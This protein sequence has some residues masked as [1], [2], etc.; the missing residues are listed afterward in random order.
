IFVQ[1]AAAQTARE[2]HTPQTERDR[3]TRYEVKRH[4][5][6]FDAEDIGSHE[7]TV[8][9][10]EAGT[11][12]AERIHDVRNFTLNVQPTADC[13]PPALEVLHPAAGD[14]LYNVFSAA[15]MPAPALPSASVTATAVSRPIS[16]I[17]EGVL[18]TVPF[19][20]LTV[21]ESATVL[22]AIP[23]RDEFYPRGFL[24]RE[25][26]LLEE[27]PGYLLTGE[28]GNAYLHLDAGNYLFAVTSGSDPEGEV[29]RCYEDA[30]Y[31]WEDILQVLTVST[32]EPVL[33]L[34]PSAETR[35]FPF[36]YRPLTVKASTP[37]GVA[38]IAL[39]AGDQQIF[40]STMDDVI[41][42][43]DPK[44]PSHLGFYKNVLF[45]HPAPAALDVTAIAAC[46]LSTTQNI[47]ISIQPDPP[48]TVGF[49]LLEEALE[50]RMGV[51][52]HLTAVVDD[53]GRNVAAL[54]A[55]LYAVGTAP[56]AA[57]LTP[58]NYRAGAAG[59][60]G[61][62]RFFE[63]IGNTEPLSIDN[64]SFQL[65]IKVRPPNVPLGDYE[66]RLLAFDDFDQAGLSAPLPIRILPPTLPPFLE[67]TLPDYRIPAGETIPVAIQLDHLGPL[68][69]VEIQ[70]VSA[71]AQPT[72][73]IIDL[74]GEAE[75]TATELIQI[76]ALASPGDTVDITV[77]AVDSA[78]LTS[79]FM[80]QVEVGVW[81]DP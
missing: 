44:R 22:F 59:E 42:T 55:V 30:C 51:Q 15:T 43:L 34:T 17:S 49:T 16:S 47:P 29:Y 32:D 79:T 65:P 78:G 58:D 57:T 40:L 45:A 64:F 2:T 38:G 46:G 37:T 52:T 54:H 39:Q 62:F 5:Y 10:R 25:E 3:N 60:L 80:D 6:T 31:D 75:F 53:P 41:Y 68:D 8:R 71:A 19:F 76:S 26:E 18:Y 28:D 67:V 1:S 12:G 73:R 4:Y 66:L 23:Y 63:N 21:T 74:E 69:H 70:A 7:L 72:V 56:D 81:G 77:T 36:D 61:T 27:I 14:T 50:L 20:N 24:Y 35:Q 48:P 33:Q 13:Q 11:D 9:V